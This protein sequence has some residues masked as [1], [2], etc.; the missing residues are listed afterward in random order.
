LRGYGLPGECLLGALPVE[1]RLEGSHALALIAL[2]EQRLPIGALCCERLLPLGL[3]VLQNSFQIADA[4]SRLLRAPALVL[5]TLLLERQL[6][7]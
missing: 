2:L 4:H 3:R 1:G 6:S 7:P 5:A